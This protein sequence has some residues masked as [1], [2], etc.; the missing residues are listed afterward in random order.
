ML[1]VPTQLQP[2]KTASNALTSYKYLVNVQGKQSK[3]MF[4]L[5]S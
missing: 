5:R 3:A 4:T 1:S 2:T